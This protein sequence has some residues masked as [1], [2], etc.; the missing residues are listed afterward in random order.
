MVSVCVIHCVVREQAIAL[1]SGQ[2]GFGSA[3]QHKLSLAYG[4]DTK[5]RET[6]SSLYAFIS[7]HHHAKLLKKA[8]S[9]KA[10][11]VTKLANAGH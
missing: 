10:A 8:P 3:E 9:S 5:S 7:R 4:L 11:T 2:S 1:N 6:L